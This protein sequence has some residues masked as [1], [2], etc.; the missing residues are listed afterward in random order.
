M[1]D[2]ETYGLVKVAARKIGQTNQFV[3]IAK[4]WNSTT[5]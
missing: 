3:G 1:F 5:E 4:I 2:V